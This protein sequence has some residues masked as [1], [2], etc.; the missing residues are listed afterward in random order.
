MIDIYETIKNRRSVRAYKPEPVPEEKLNRILEAVRMAP[1]AHNSQPYKLIIVRDGQ[2]RKQ[3]AVAAN[4]Q[5]FVGEA[6]IIIAIVSL[7]AEHLMSCDV[8]TYA[9]DCAIAIDHLSL[10]A[11]AEGLGTC[12]I[13]SFS[14][15][16]TK[17]VLAVSPEYKIVI[18]MPLGFPADAVGSKTRKNLKELICKEIFS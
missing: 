2:K 15:S 4:N 5:T 10:A 16:K 9:I 11:A 17:Q 18:L 7:D 3:L 6:P 1:S 8:P 13:G 14:Q 12:W